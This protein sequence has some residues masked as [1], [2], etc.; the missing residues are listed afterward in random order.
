M[1]PRW[2]LLLALTGAPAFADATRTVGLPGLLD[3]AMDDSDRAWLETLAVFS[4][5][6]QLAALDIVRV[7]SGALA[8]VQVDA[9][10]ENAVPEIRR[11]AALL[12]NGPALDAYV[13][14]VENIEVLRRLLAR[15]ADE[16]S[17]RRLS[18]ML[19]DASLESDRLLGL[20]GTPI[21]EALAA[22]IRLRL[23]ELLRG[24]G[25]VSGVYD[26]AAFRVEWPHAVARAVTFPALVIEVPVTTDPRTQSVRALTSY[27]VARPDVPVTWLAPV[28]WRASPV[29]GP[30][31]RLGAATLL[32]ATMSG[33]QLRLTYSATGLESLRQV[34][35]WLVPVRL[36]GRFVSAAGQEI[37][38]AEVQAAIC[39]GLR[40]APVPAIRGCD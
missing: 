18:R 21:P 24:I 25:V 33:S 20:V 19:D 8:S 13:R 23:F 17:R 12:G 4:R 37:D 3:V 7:P 27:R 32:D 34:S 22:G 14:Q 9:A 36:G 5:G 28:S 10:V 30:A 40:P 31:Q 6:G 2:L 1:S 39:L 15:A 26:D 16:R 29:E 35:S 11:Q 38:V